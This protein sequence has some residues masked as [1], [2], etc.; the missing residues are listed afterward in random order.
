MGYPNDADARGPQT[1]ELEVLSKAVIPAHVRA[2]GEGLHGVMRVAWGDAH[3][4]AGRM[5]G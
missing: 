2:T 1:G 4:G 5:P 3:A